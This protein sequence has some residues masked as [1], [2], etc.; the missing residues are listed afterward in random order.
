MSVKGRWYNELG[1][2]MDLEVNGDLIEGIYYTA[3]GD[4]EGAY[5]LRGVI[6]SKGDPNSKGQAIAWVVVWKNKK[7]NSGSVTAWSGQ[8]QIIDDGEEEIVTLWLL[9]KEE[10]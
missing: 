8:Y 7:S 4:A 6:D 9:T 2:Y 10:S 5:Q 3:V 1:S